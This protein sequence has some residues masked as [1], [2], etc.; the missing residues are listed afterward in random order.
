MP[1]SALAPADL[2]M[3][4]ASMTA[5]PSV[6]ESHPR[7]QPWKKHWPPKEGTETE[8]AYGFKEGAA[9]VIYGN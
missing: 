6:P 3:Q 2:Q 9:V 1:L 4:T 8:N 5:T 7:T